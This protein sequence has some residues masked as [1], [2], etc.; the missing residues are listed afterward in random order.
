MG[1]IKNILFVC[2]GNSCRS[3]MAEFLLKKMIKESGRFNLEKFKIL[4]AGI[5]PMEGMT[6]PK[7][8]I[9]VL[10]NE[11]INVSSYEAK[12]VTPK[13]IKKADLVL[14]M[15]DY[16]KESVNSISEDEEKI[17]LLKEY[18]ASGNEGGNLNIP[19]PIGKPLESYEVCLKTIKECL[20][21]LIQKL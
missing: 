4:S 15:Q 18:C 7:N 3:V 21:K 13:M 11:G 1:K 9:E 5:N 17:Y 2:T 14:V 16:H 12:R 20:N 6:P 19:D 10:K 8:T